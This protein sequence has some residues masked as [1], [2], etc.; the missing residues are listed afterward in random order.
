MSRSYAELPFRE[1]KVYKT[2]TIL[3]LIGTG[4]MSSVFLVNKK[5]KPGELYALKYRIQDNN[6]NNYI[7]FKREIELLQK[8]SSP[9]VPKIFDY[10]ID[11]KEQYFVMEYVNGKSLRSMI[12]E[13]GFLN[14]RLAVSFAKQ[15]AAGIGELHS[16]GIVH[17]DIKSS[18]ILISDK[19]TVKIIDLGISMSCEHNNQRLTKTHSIVGSVYYL[20]PELIDDNTKITKQVDIYALGVLL[21]EMLTGKYPFSNKNAIQTIQMHKENEFP[22]VKDFREVPQALENVILK[23]T[24]KNPN[25][26][27]ESMWEFRKDIDT[28]LLTSRSLEAPISTKTAKSKKTIADYTSSWRFNVILISVL[29]LISVILITISIL[30]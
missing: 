15:I 27:Y 20:A 25:N 9:N 18:N 11:E 24:A 26:R 23:A 29:I 14:S 22:R 5:N 12:E 1:S 19:L 6:N 13:N 30:I 8:I 10:H 7:R 17:R 2:Y 28:C 21:F 16:N 4:G 3:K